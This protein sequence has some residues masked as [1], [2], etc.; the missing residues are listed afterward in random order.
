MMGYLVNAWDWRELG[1]ASAR[2][3]FTCRAS[4]NINKIHTAFAA[5]CATEFRRLAPTLDNF[6]WLAGVDGAAVVE[7]VAS[8]WDRWNYEH[9]LDSAIVEL[10]IILSAGIEAVFAPLGDAA[11]WLACFSKPEAALLAKEL[12][13][14]EV[15]VRH[16][17]N[18]KRRP[19]LTYEGRTKDF[20]IRGWLRAARLKSELVQSLGESRAD[21]V[22]DLPKLVL[23]LL[24]SIVD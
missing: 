15:Q 16:W 8:L 2:K 20:S 6:Q 3:Y 24:P 13:V 19:V 10:S 22:S 18:G 1:G 12:R 17:L 4:R 23:E 5:H 11:G 21:M 14:D 7:R 9:G